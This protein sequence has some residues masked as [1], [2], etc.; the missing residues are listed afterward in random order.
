MKKP[1][2]FTLIELLVVIAIIAILAALLLPALAQAKR[3]AQLAN[4]LSN[5][6]QVGV[7]LGMYADDNVQWL[8]PGPVPVGDPNV[9]TALQETEAP[10]YSGP[11]AASDFRKM[12]PYYL[13]TYTGNAAPASVGFATN[14]VRVL[15]C[16]AY[17]SSLPG[18]TI[19][20]YNPATDNYYDAYCYSVTRAT[21]GPSTGANTYTWSIPG[22]PFGKENVSQP[23][24]MTT[25]VSSAPLP[26]VWVVADLDTNA[27]IDPS[28]L[29]NPLGYV[30]KSP[31]HG[32]VRSILYFDFHA[33]P[34]KVTTPADYAQ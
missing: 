4:C 34:V 5:Y 23:L 15:L 24:R 21:N 33:A 16:P 12:L 14:L 29:G 19:L 1:R 25:L 3:K 2:A 27:V 31:V 30:A 8:P 20:H 18:N 13:A 9:V 26:L 32:H 7:A 6:K 17:I 10:V 22:L 28:S 11:N